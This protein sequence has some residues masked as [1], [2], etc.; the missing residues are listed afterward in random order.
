MVN[1]GAYEGPSLGKANFQM[2]IDEPKILRCL[3]QIDNKFHLTLKTVIQ[4]AVSNNGG[5][6]ESLII[7]CAME[8]I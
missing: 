7:K 4:Y 2:I 6:F 5:V 3:A 1:A 8:E